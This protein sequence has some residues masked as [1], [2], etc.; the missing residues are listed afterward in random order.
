VGEGNYNLSDLTEQIIGA[1]FEVSNSLGTGF[2]EKVYRNA[3]FCELRDRGIHAEMEKGISV[4]YKSK[5]VGEY[6]A[7][8]LVAGKILVEVKCASGIADAHT[9]QCINYL[10]ATRL[11]L[12]LLINFGNPKVEIKRV[13][14]NYR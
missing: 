2:L 10:K 8:I 3:L 4:Y 7:D 6:F 9:A 5:I 13:V 11:S 14:N 12:C 1:A